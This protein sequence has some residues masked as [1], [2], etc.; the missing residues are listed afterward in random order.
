MKREDLIA[1]GLSEELVNQIMALHGQGIQREQERNTQTAADLAAAQASLASV[2]AQLQSFEGVDV[3][4]LQAS[5]QTL[6]QQLANDAATHARELSARD[7]AA[8]T[9]VFLAG[10][11]FVNTPTRDYFT[12]KLNE[13]LESDDSRGK[14]REDLLNALTTDKDGNPM[15]GI[16]AEDNPHK[17][18]IN[19]PPAD[20][21]PP[22]GGEQNPWSKEHWNMK[23]QKEIFEADKARAKALAQMAGYNNLF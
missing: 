23:R 6:Q 17:A 7:R 3:T 5:V 12:T 16:F 9:T 1:L 11:N 21:V 20:R 15:P 18:I 22:A 4:G 19:L 14:S 2:Q 10:R 8:E 13:L